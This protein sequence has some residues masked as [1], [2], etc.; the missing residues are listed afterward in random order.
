MMMRLNLRILGLSSVLLFIV[1]AL[2]CTQPQPASNSNQPTAVST[3]GEKVNGTRGGTVT[4]RLTTPPDTLNYLAATNESSY[5]LAFALLGGKLID[6]DGETQ[7]YVPGLAESWR[8][9]DDARA[10]N[11]ALRNDLK[12]SDGHPLTADDVVFTMKAIYDE[13]TQSPIFRDAMLIGGKQIEVTATDPT[14]LRFVFP[15][16][17]ASP[18]SF[19]SNVAVLPKHVLEGDLERGTLKNAWAIDA[20]PASV[21][22]A[23]AFVVDSVTPG[24]RIALKRNPNYWKKDSAGTQLPYLDSLNL[25]VV[26]DSNNA[27]AQLQQG[28]LDIVDRIPA[29]DYASLRN[30]TGAVR[31]FDL[32][33]G[34]G[35]DHFFFNLNEKT[36]E[37]KAIDP[38]K[39][40]WF[41]NLNFRRAISHAIDRQALAVSTLQGLATP[42]KGLV[43]PGNK[44]WSATDLPD[45]DY[46]LEKAKTLL[47]EAGF[48]V[49]GSSDAPELYDGKGNRVQFTLIVP[50]ESAPRKNIA[51][52]IQADLAKLGI[53]MEVA[54]LEFGQLTKRVTDSF[55]YD[56]AM[57]GTS[58]TQPD[59]SSYDT[60]IRSDSNNHQWRPN[61][62]RPATDWE[63]RLDEMD[64]AMARETNEERRKGIFR[65]I[66]LLIV[67]QMRI[68]PVVARHI[69][70]AVNTRVGNYRPS[71]TVPYSLWNADELF[72]KK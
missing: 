36:K 10:L 31:A 17:V 68:I 15:E 55:D 63:A 3:P 13:R 27:I 72:V 52:L 34:L 42:L 21:V 48:Q 49:K 65:D 1:F 64:T 60:F 29:T 62:E 20:N 59:P 9:S 70:S 4:Y 45:T 24:R 30:A 8:F 25:V 35:T 33:P 32:G 40:S 50:A 41:D 28:S 61:Q 6:F 5:T 38:D 67:E 53:K 37:G 56:A 22:T 2:A 18:E 71:T 11:L 46:D 66:Q 47:R 12:F 43:S 26:P 39:A 23:G 44:Q 51:T 14:H 19:L 16:T 54:P 69:S 58:P 57:L 7:R